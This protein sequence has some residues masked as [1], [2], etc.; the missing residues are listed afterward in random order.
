MRKFN[1]IQL[2]LPANQPVRIVSIIFISE[3]RWKKMI[4]CQWSQFYFII[5]RCG[6]QMRI[7]WFSSNICPVSDLS[8]R[9]SIYISWPLFFVSFCFACSLRMFSSSDI[10]CLKNKGW[11]DK[12]KTGKHMANIHQAFWWWTL[13]HSSKNSHERCVRSVATAQ[14]KCRQREGERG[15]F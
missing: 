6:I 12:K 10:S 9:S 13:N 7:H 4:L 8:V 3:E 14:K 11:P 2:C 15:L 5:T 1:K